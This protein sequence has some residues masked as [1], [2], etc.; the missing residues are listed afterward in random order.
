[1]SLLRRERG[2]PG[3]DGTPG[4]GSSPKFLTTPVLGDIPV[5]CWAF[6][7]L[8]VLVR[9]FNIDSPLFDW[10]MYRQFDTAALARNFFEEGMNPFYPRVDWRGASPGFVEAEFQIYTYA[11]ALLYHVFGPHEWV[12][13]VLN[14]GVYVVSALLLFRFTER[15]FSR[16]VAVFAVL[17]YS[18]VPLSVYQTRAFQPDALL[19]LGSIAG[20]YYFW[21]WTEEGGGRFFLLSAAGVAVAALIKPP[22]LYLGLPLL[23]LAWRKFGAGLL[24]VGK[25]WLFAALVLVPT[26]LWYWHAYGLWVE[27]GNTFGIFGRRTIAGIWP[28]GDPHW[29]LL[30]KMLARRLT[31]QIATPAGLVLLGIGL[32]GSIVHRRS[33]RSGI[34]W[35]W[36]AGFALF[37]LLVPRGNYGH[38]YYQLPVVFLTAAWMGY[39]TRLLLD[40]GRI[41]RWATAVL[42]VGFI[43]L[44]ARQLQPLISARSRHYVEEKIA[45]GERMQEITDP[46][47]LVVFI[48]RRPASHPP[49]IYRHRTVDGQYILCHPMDFYLSR[50]KGWNPDDYQ[51]TPEFLE[52][53]RRQGARWVATTRVATLEKRQPELRAWLESAYTP[54]EVTE[55]W[56]IYR[57]DS[58]PRALADGT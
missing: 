24:R 12:G 37:V 20:V 43:G 25:L 35:A 51:A 15:A 44:S 8:A 4:L 6:V 53:V 28:I 49:E 14:I 58:P 5:A 1:M 22:G 29:G 54:V 41:V 30:A 16:S 23:Y 52:R 10:Q 39:G 57:M 40:R 46:E 34:L 17:F 36:L 18:F 7:G 11:V 27:Y 55:D 33:L 56:L 47:D 3:G 13:R 2:A 45:F 32:L 50:R 38:N 26:A 21:R 48:E 9:L 19:A 31:Y 42:V